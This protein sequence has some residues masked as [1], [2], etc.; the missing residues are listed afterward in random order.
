VSGRWFALYRLLP[1]WHATEPLVLELRRVLSFYAK[2]APELSHDAFR[3]AVE[4]VARVEIAI[5]DVPPTPALL[6]QQ[7]Q[8]QE[9]VAAHSQL[10]GVARVPSAWGDECVLLARICFDELPATRELPRCGVLLVVCARRDANGAVHGV[11]AR[12]V[13]DERALHRRVP[14]RLTS[15]KLAFPLRSLSFVTTLSLPPPQHAATP[16]ALRNSAAY[17]FLCGAWRDARTARGRHSL[18]GYAQSYDRSRSAARQR[19]CDE[20]AAWRGAH[21]GG[22]GRD[23]YGVCGRRPLLTLASDAHLPGAIFAAMSACVAWT[24]GA[25]GESEQLRTLA[26]AE[27][28]CEVELKVTNE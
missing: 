6:L 16:S 15:G 27:E 1:H 14:T 17:A 13:R 10:G 8:Q 28:G 18:L 23:V 7:Q 12:Y 24:S 4:D 21:E 2:R 26:E 5:R 25:R 11:A 3:W 20:A 22:C 9:Q 19:E